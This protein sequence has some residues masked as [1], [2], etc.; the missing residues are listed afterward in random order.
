MVFDAG[1]FFIEVDTPLNRWSTKF[2][3][4]FFRRLAYFTNHFRIAHRVTFTLSC[5]LRCSLTFFND[6]PSPYSCKARTMCSGFILIRLNTSSCTYHLPQEWQKY[7]CFEPEAL[8]LIPFFATL[9][10]PQS[11]HISIIITSR[12]RERRTCF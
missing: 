10:D 11:S 4:V 9:F 5:C 1:I 8:C 12:K 6:A 7:F 3:L 2:L